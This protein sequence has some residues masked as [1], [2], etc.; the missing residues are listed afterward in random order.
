MTLFKKTQKLL[1]RFLFIFF[2]EDRGLLPPNISRKIL[3]EW[4]QLEELNEY[5]PLF[6]HC[7]KHFGYLNKGFKGKRYSIFAY[8]GGLF[9]NDKVLDKVKIDDNILYNYIFTLSGY[10]FASEIS[11]N[12]L[13]HIF[14]HSL[15]EIEEIQA[16]INAD[17]PLENIGKRKKECKKTQKTA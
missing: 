1:D 17:K 11:V 2:A 8:N 12:I 5:R 4:Q 9:S 13:G 7:K 16:E 15:T 10:D 6:Q 14:E 3:S